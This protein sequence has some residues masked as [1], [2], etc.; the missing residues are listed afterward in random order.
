[1]KLSSE[2]STFTKLTSTV[3][4]KTKIVF[5]IHTTSNFTRHKSTSTENK[6]AQEETTILPMEK[7]R[8]ELVYF[9]TKLQFLNI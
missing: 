7:V 1:M 4:N 6:V 5:R 3:F 2:N 8:N 9:N